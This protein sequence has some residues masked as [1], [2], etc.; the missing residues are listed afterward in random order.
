MTSRFVLGAVAV[1]SLV[2]LAACTPTLP[3]ISPSASTPT[4]TATVAPTT[5]TVAPATT[6]ATPSPTAT[7]VASGTRHA[8]YFDSARAEGGTTYLS[9]DIVLFLGGPEAEDAAEAAGAESPPPNDYFIVNDSEKVREYAVTP[10]VE[11]QTVMA[12]DGSFC[13]DM[14]CPP[15]T[16]D[17]WLAAATPSGSLFRSG[18]YWITV[19]GTTITGIEQQYLP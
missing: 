18:P 11:V 13:P 17:A 9:F 14:T 8:A 6:T 15:M 7:P 5:T 12:A 16:L 10:G 4:A 2:S 3:T 1:V 19:N